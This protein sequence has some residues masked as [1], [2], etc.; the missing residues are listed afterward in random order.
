MPHFPNFCTIFK[1]L[2]FKNYCS[3]HEKT[4][5]LEK[6]QYLIRILSELFFCNFNTSIR[7]QDRIHNTDLYSD[8]ATEMN[9]DPCGSG[10]SIL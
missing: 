6:R 1:Y 4:K 10:S 3:S 7:I 2:A 9:T 8:P 5:K